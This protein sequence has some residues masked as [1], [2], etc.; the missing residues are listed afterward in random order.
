MLVDQPGPDYFANLAERPLDEAYA[1][2]TTKVRITQDLAGLDAEH[3][4]QIQPTLSGW[5]IGDITDP[6]RRGVIDRELTGQH[7]A[8]DRQVIVAVSRTGPETAPVY[9]PPASIA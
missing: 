7:I 3:Y 4:G 2:S 8:C 5:E 6:S 9:A 1:M